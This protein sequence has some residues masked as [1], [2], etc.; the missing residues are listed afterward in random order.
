ALTTKLWETESAGYF[1]AYFDTNG[2]DGHDALVFWRGIDKHFVLRARG[3]EDVPAQGIEKFWGDPG[4]FILRIEPADYARME[5][6]VEYELAWAGNGEPAPWK[7]RAGAK[8]ERPAGARPKAAPAAA[9]KAREL[10][11]ERLYWYDDRPAELTTKLSEP[12]SAGHLFV[13][14]AANGMDGKEAMALWQG[15]DKR[16]GL[17]ARGHDDVPAEGIEKY[18]GNGDGGDF[19]LRI[20]P[21]DYARM[22]RGV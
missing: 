17:R 15:A 6:G 10:T 4:V 8:I 11:L 5:G 19:I 16:F 12:E 3:H 13:H 18:W 2:V 9:S 7:V 21:A 20:E 14:F 1:F 22:A